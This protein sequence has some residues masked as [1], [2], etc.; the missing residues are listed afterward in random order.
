MSIDRRRFIGGLGLGA[1]GLAVPSVLSAPTAFA[2]VRPDAEPP[3]LDAA[4]AALAAHGAR[5]PHRDRLGLVDFSAPSGSARF[6]IVDIGNG[7]VLANW[8]VAHGR[9]SDPAN[10]GVLQR[11]SN[12]P[13][14]NASSSGS[15]LIGETYMG[16]YGRSRRLHG[17]DPENDMALAGAIATHSADYVREDMA[18]HAGRVGRS[19]GCFTVSHADIAE[20]LALLGPG[21]LLYAARQ[22]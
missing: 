14:S 11:F 3:L 4:R 1:A 12:R 21:R 8:L 15:F 18:R 13:G 16:K 9:G 5:I 7:R 17:L 22:T 10:T 6:R 20:V 2:A 19:L